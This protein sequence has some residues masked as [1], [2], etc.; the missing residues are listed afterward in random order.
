MARIVSFIILVVIVLVLVGLFLA[1]MAEFL[2]P[3]FLA[4][5]LVVLFRPLH[6]WL[7]RKLGNR[8]RTAAGLTTLVIALAVLVP[9]LFVLSQ[10]AIEAYA[11]RG[12]IDAAG[13][14][15]FVA[16]RFAQGQ[17]FAAKLHV[18]I[19]VEAEWIDSATAQLKS[20][21]APA[22]LRTTQ[23][24]GSFFFGLVIMLVSAY[25]FLLDGPS[26]VRTIMRLSP[27]DDAYERQLI[28]EFDRVSRAVVAATLLSALAQ[29]LVAGIGYYFAGVPSVV[30]WTVLSALLALVPFVGAAIIWVPACL[31]LFDEDHLGAAIFLTVWCLVLV[32]LVDNLVKP[33]VLKGQSNI[34]PLLALLSVLGGA[35]ALGPIGILVGPMVVAF[36]QALLNIL[37]H[38]IKALDAAKGDGPAAPLGAEAP[39]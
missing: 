29:G 11:L 24:L 3:L 34:H 5:L 17:R 7:R 14:R 15:Q 38:E 19:P 9:I 1:V 25:F 23:F 10:A 33:W 31:W 35:T 37:Q 30:L 21:L 32:S 27:L 8:E 16:A 12:Q 6:E 22:A 13:L 36:L 18:T 26:M 28:D 20:W 4:L 2:L 39:H